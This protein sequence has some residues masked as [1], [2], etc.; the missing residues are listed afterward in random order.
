[1]L[2]AHPEVCISSPKEPLYFSKNYGL[3]VDWYEKCFIDNTSAV[4]VDASPDYSRG[5]TD[6][7][8]VENSYDGENF[9]H[10]PKRIYEYNPEAKFIY[11]MRNPISRTYSSYWHNVRAGYES[12]TFETCIRQS[13]RY[14][15]ASDYFG[16][17]QN[18]LE[19]FE[20]DQ[21]HFMIFEKFIRDSSTELESCC[22]FLSINYMPE[23]SV[24][25]VH[26]NASYQLNP[27]AKRMRKL[28]G[29]QKRFKSFSR[30][31][32]N[33]LP[34]RV[35]IHLKNITTETIPKIMETDR[36]YL[37]ELFT[38]R[39]AKLEKL[40]GLDLSIWNEK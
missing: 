14:L 40:T 32:Q 27:T 37:A 16:Q 28:L 19:I 36:K 21:F 6:M 30:S 10:I 1:M 2:D 11:I 15:V 5:P 4:L 31:L 23:L 35:Q 13:D 12:A 25:K 26:K 39:N 22:D 34:E 18:Y 9:Q 8:P 33:V 38:E 29:S 24:E 17:I 20:K 7:F 3:G